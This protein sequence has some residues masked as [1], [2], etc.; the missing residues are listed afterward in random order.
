MILHS[1]ATM[2]GMNRVGVINPGRYTRIE[3]A[4]HSYFAIPPYG[5]W[6]SWRDPRERRN[7]DK[8][9]VPL[10]FTVSLQPDLRVV[11][12]RLG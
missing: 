8:P 4:Y 5:D 12:A 11:L 10:Y 7:T 9:P 1:G 2:K 6:L 3:C